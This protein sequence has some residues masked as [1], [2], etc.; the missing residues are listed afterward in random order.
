MIED[1][2][3]DEI[4]QGTG[5]ELRGLGNPGL[6]FGRRVTAKEGEVCKDVQKE[7]LAI[8]LRERT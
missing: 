5:V 6:I 3:V 1:I 8:S 2:M 4:S 7:P